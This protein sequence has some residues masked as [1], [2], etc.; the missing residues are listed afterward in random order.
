MLFYE[1]HHLPQVDGLIKHGHYCAGL[2]GAQPR[3]SRI[4]AHYNHRHI[5]Q[6]RMERNVRQEGDPVHNWHREVEQDQFW[7]R[8]VGLNRFESA[9]TIF[10]GKHRIAGTVEYFTQSLS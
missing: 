6:L 8:A 1:C 10:G 5:H 7:F 2:L 9:H 4:S 3:C